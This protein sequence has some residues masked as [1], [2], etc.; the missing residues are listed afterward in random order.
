[1]RVV[2]SKRHS[3]AGGEKLYLVGARAPPEPRSDVARV[4][5]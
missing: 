5:V 4:A 3:V 1:M 2:V